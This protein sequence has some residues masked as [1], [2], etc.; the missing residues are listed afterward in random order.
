MAAD[1]Q[2]PGLRE[3]VGGCASLAGRNGDLTR[4]GAVLLLGAVFV[5]PLNGL[6]AQ[7]ELVVNRVSVVNDEPYGVA[8]PEFIVSRV[9]PRMVDAYRDRLL[10]GV[11]ACGARP[12]ERRRKQKGNERLAVHRPSEA[13]LPAPASMIAAPIVARAHGHHCPG[14]LG[15]A[16]AE[17]GS[18][19]PA[20]T[21]DGRPPVTFIA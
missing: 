21:G 9:E 19:N 20:S 12:E 2:S 15:T 7:D 1:D 6:I 11:G 3:R 13:N 16:P 5:A 17:Y 18:F 14:S 10:A 8:G 4:N